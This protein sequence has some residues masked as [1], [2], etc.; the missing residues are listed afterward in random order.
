MAGEFIDNYKLATY[1]QQPEGD[2]DSYGAMM[3]EN[4]AKELGTP[5]HRL[6]SLMSPMDVRAL[7]DNHRAL[8]IALLLL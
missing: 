3:V 8:R 7:R 4:I 5:R 2:I 1:L 6:P